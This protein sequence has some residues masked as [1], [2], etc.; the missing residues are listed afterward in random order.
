MRSKTG[1][2]VDEKAEAVRYVSLTKNHLIFLHVPS[3]FFC[4]RTLRKEIGCC[5]LFH[6]G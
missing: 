6:E 2:T 1:V 4:F 5:V 3:L